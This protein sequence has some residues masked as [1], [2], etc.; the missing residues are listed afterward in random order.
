MRRSVNTAAFKIFRTMLVRFTRFLFAFV[1][2]KQRYEGF[3][4]PGAN[5]AGKL[6]LDILFPVLASLEA[7]RNGRLV[8]N[9]HY[10]SLS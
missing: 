7:V 4:H 8:I 1:S 6:Y 2:W 5:L 3:S 9:H 10:L